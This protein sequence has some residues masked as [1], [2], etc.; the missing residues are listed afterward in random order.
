MNIPTMPKTLAAASIHSEIQPRIMP[1][2]RENRGAMMFARVPPDHVGQNANAT[3]LT[4]RTAVP[5]TVLTQEKNHQHRRDEEQKKRL[6]AT[7]GDFCRK[8][9][10]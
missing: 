5:L 9:W 7:P 2:K 6:S 3:V 1:I 8:I 10:L 4:R